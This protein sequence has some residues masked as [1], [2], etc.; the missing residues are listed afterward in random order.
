MPSCFSEQLGRKFST[1][2]LEIKVLSNKH[3]QKN[4]TQNFGDPISVAVTP[5]Q[6]SAMPPDRRGSRDPQAREQ[7]E[8]SFRSSSWVSS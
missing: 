3:D 4:A 7:E 1:E 2:S 6:T 5:Y 8:E